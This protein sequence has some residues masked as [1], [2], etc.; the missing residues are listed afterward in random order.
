[1]SFHKN[2]NRVRQLVIGIHKIKKL[3]HACETAV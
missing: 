1:M 2:K 3:N